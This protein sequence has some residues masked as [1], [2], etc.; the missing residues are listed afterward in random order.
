MDPII[1][2][3]V[4]RIRQNSKFKSGGARPLRNKS[5]APRPMRPPRFRHLWLCHLCGLQLWKETET[6]L[7]F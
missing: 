7:T 4:K 5:G 1:I 3:L 6:T 2:V